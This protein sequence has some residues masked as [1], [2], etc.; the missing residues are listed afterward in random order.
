MSL[1]GQ[2]ILC[3]FSG[4]HKSV[5]QVHTA[6]PPTGQHFLL[7]RPSQ[8]TCLQVPSAVFQVTNLSLFTFQLFLL[9]TYVMRNKA[10]QANS[11][12]S[13]HNQKQTQICIQKSKNTIILVLKLTFWIARP[14]NVDHSERKH[15][16]R[17]MTYDS[18]EGREPEERES[19][20]ERGQIQLTAFV[21]MWGGVEG[22]ERRKW[23]TTLWKIRF[24]P[25]ISE[26]NYKRT[27]NQF[28]QPASSL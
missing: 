3:F 27:E 16:G 19:N 20:R 7:L 10:R 17:V 6:Y 23:I 24:L 8:C 1:N 28:P 18:N 12:K 26:W 11:A 13:L 9:W 5:S 25:I 2:C 4:C 14:L 21:N 22:W 15:S